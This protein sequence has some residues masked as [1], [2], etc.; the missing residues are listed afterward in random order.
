MTKFNIGIPL[1]SNKI[2][3]LYY[4]LSLSESSRECLFNKGKL[5]FKTKANE[6]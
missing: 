6:R 3:N 5:Y 2:A 4:M 1:A